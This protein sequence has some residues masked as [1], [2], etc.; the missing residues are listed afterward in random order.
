[1]SNILQT[2]TT[3]KHHV[4]TVKFYRSRTNASLMSHMTLA[5][6][7]HFMTT[8]TFTVINGIFNIIP[9]E[10]F[11]NGLQTVLAH[12]DASLIPNTPQLEFKLGRIICKHLVFDSNGPI[13]QVPDMS[14]QCIIVCNVKLMI[15]C[16]M[17]RLF[18]LNITQLKITD[19][20]P[21]GPKH[22]IIH[23]DTE[24]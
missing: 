4:P 19:D 1:M 3:W 11:I 5:G 2:N 24:R 23:A 7:D 17:N 20:I 10:D 14:G 21:P 18:D 8:G 6:A 13:T 15:T 16:E 22:E 9:C 12:I